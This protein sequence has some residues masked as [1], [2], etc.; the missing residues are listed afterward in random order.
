[1]LACSFSTL[2]DCP[3]AS[4]EPANKEVCVGV[5]YFLIK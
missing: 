1:M 4:D 5:E 2:E 3:I